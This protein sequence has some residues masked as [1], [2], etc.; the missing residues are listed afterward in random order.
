[1]SVKVVLLFCAGVVYGLVIGLLG[2][3]M[4]NTSVMNITPRSDKEVKKLTRRINVRWWLKLLIDAVALFL[5]YRVTPMLLG[6]ALG[7]LAAQKIFIVKTIK[8]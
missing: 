2:F 8:S 5:L 7:L 6:A 4:M 3:K 1:M